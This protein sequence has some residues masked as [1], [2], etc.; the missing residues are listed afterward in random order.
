M[1]KRLKVR[2]FDDSALSGG[3]Q[4]EGAEAGSHCDVVGPWRAPN[5]TH[6]PNGTQAARTTIA[7][8]HQLGKV[9]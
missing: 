4:L 3:R 1:H 6:A 7:S 8:R 2:T 5:G 9:A